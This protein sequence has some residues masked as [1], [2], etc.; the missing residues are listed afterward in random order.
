MAKGKP[1]IPEHITKYA[2]LKK[3]AKGILEATKITHSEA[4]I[5]AAKDLL[6]DESGGIDYDRLDDED[7][8]QQVADAMLDHYLG[9]ANKYFGTK[10]KK[11]DR[12]QADMLLNAYT[13]TTR[14]QL[15]YNIRKKGKRYT[16]DAHEKERDNLLAEIEKQLSATAA[17]H[18]KDEHAE[19]FVKHM[20]LDDLVDA[21]RM[22]VQDIATLHGLYE[23]HGAVTEPMLEKVYGRKPYILKEKKK[24]KVIKGDFGGEDQQAYQKAA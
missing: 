22:R 3:K 10:L 23:E 20:G 24:G 19:D 12:I 9:A 16:I 4:Y 13:G 18:L 6:T 2:Q 21:S 1:V 8:Q 15:E 17:G 14:T 7:I 5:K 11:D